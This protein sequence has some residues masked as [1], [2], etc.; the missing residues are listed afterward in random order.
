MRRYSPVLMDETP[1]DL[2]WR[3]W[4]HQTS[5]LRPE[6]LRRT[7]LADDRM[8]DAYVRTVDC[9]RDGTVTALASTVDPRDPACALSIVEHTDR[10]ASFLAI[11]GSCFSA[12]GLPNHANSTFA[13]N[14]A[15]HGINVWVD[16][17]LP[18]RFRLA[19]CVG[20]V[21]G[22]AQLGE[23]LFVGHGCT[24]GASTDEEYPVLG[25]GVSLRAHSSI[26]GRCE[27]GNNVAISAGVTLINTDVPENSLVVSREGRPHIVSSNFA[28]RFNHKV[29]GDTF[30]SGL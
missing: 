23:Y 10:Y 26:L 27:I 2:L 5:F 24:I 28:Q 14:K 1:V 21:I 30:T 7:E 19:H 11:L 13:L 8:S 15:L 16:V 6:P 22:K 9:L 17:T 12:G 29:F 20:T 25:R 3:Y 18:R 4:L